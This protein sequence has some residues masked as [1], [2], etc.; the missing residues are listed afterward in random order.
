VSGAAGYGQQPV[1][2]AA[3]YGHQPVSGAAGYGH[4][5]VSGAAGYGQQPV[6]GAP[7]APSGSA[8]PVSVPPA[9]GPTSGGAVYGTGSTAP[10]DSEATQRV[11]PFPPAPARPVGQ[12]PT[13]YRQAAQPATPVYPPGVSRPAYREPT[14][15]QPAYRE[16]A[17]REPA[18]AE[19]AY[20]APAERTR[21]G[22]GARRV[23]KTVF[24][25]VLLVLVPIVCGYV[26]YRYTS[27]QSLLP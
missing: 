6:S 26:A 17:Y 25:T 14:Y 10:P 7:G 20:V 11:G 1:S 18:Y 9:P 22:S 3:G 8:Q 23:L 24:V 19:P 5:P 21:R 12:P 4:Q 27:N 15:E 13:N 2:G 16:P